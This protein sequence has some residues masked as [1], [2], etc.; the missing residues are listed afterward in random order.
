M[1]ESEEG[2]GTPKK[3]PA[4][5]PPGREGGSESPLG[6]AGGGLLRPADPLEARAIDSLKPRWVARPKTRGELSECLRHAAEGKLA[7]VAIGGGN[8]IDLGGPLQRYDLA[9]VTTGL[10]GVIDYQ[11]ADMTVTVEAG[12]G[13]GAL[14]DLLG[15]RG[16]WLPIDPPSPERQTVG[17][18]IAANLWGPCRVSQGRIRDFLLGVRIARPDGTVVKCGGRVVK[19][20]AGYDLPK[21][22]VGS[23][24]TLGVIVEATMKVQPTPELIR[25][26]VVDTATGVEAAASLG[27]RLADQRLAPF[28]SAAFSGGRA[29]GGVECG[30]LVAFAGSPRQVSWQVGELGERLAHDGLRPREVG[31]QAYQC[32]RDRPLREANEVAWRAALLPR[33]AG[34]FAAAMA[35]EVNRVARAARL[36][37]VV[38][39]D[40]GSIWASAEG[41]DSIED[42]A[43]L[44]LG[45]RKKVQRTGGDLALCRAPVEL[46]RLAGVWSGSGPLA[47][48]MRRLKAELDPQ[49]ILAPGRFGGGM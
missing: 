31:A 49:G 32:L 43:A 30:L 25:Y 8:F 23:L 3:R 6:S 38:I 45:W 12:V 22:Y 14:A 17:G 20:V 10:G 40:C 24:G 48:L 4:F 41:V 42:L 37:L 21:L 15:A 1:T 5:E 27:L 34:G 26:F 35:E 16:Q 36:S 44:T 28:I 7:T 2:G 39:P 18:L 46:K 29:V 47:A 9:L 33:L 13:L 11:P 19:N